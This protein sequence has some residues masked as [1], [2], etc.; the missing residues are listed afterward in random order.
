MELYTKEIIGVVFFALRFIFSTTVAVA[1]KSTKSR[2]FIVILLLY[3]FP[4]ITSACLIVKNKDNVKFVYTTVISYLLFV[5]CMMIALSVAW[6]VNS[7]THTRYYDLQGKAN[8]Y[9]F[10]VD[11]YDREGNAYSYKFEKSG[12]DKLYIN[13]TDEYLVVDLCFVDEDGYLVYDDDCSIVAKSENCCMDTDGKIYI[14]LC[15]AK[16]DKDGNIIKEYSIYQLHYDRFG[17]AYPYERVPVYDRNGNKYFYTF[18]SSLQQGFYTDVK[19]KKSYDNTYSFVDENGYFVY[20]ENK[21]FKRIDNGSD[22][23][24][25]VS[26]DGEHYFFASSVSWNSDGNL[27]YFH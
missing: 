2:R 5:I 23:M 10:D 21:E 3:L 13:N 25:Y 9:M 14:P 4:L 8:T 17:N 7:G 27:Q 12:Y 19:S 26:P 15:D 11:Y 18:D 6:F 22:V 1:N 20:D 16:Y 24:E